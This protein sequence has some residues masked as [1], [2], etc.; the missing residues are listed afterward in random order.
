MEVSLLSLERI[1]GEANSRF[2]WTV[3]RKLSASS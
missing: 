3:S 1:D 2:V